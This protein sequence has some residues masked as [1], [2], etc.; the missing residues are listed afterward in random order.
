[1]I[2]T[3]SFHFVG[4]ICHCIVSDNSCHIKAVKLVENSFGNNQLL[5][6]HSFTQVSSK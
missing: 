2:I 5:V 6:K 1:M 3:S 4:I